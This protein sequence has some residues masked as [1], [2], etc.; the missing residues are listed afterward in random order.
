MRKIKIIIGQ[1]FQ[2]P[3]RLFS[4][5]SLFVFITE[6]QIHPTAAVLTR[7]RIYWSIVG[8]YSYVADHCWIIKAEIGNFCSI[9]SNVM[10][11]G[12]R[13]PENFVSTSPVFY[14]RRNVLNKC[15]AEVQ[16]PEYA[17]TVIGND[18]WI[19]S[20]AF[21]KGGITIGNGAIIGAHSVVTKNVEPYT[22]VAGNPA[23]VIRKRFDDDVIKKLEATKWWEYSEEKLRQKGAHFQSVADF[24]SSM[25][26][27]S[28]K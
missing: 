3:T 28:Q 20:N 1:F 16:F 8:R 12:G 14:S 22:I 13:H 27:S 10:I 17:K 19:G 4:K 26:N 18:V 15:F 25:D 2:L 5:T 9:A 7:T 6:S 24:L 21:V 11:G 23:R